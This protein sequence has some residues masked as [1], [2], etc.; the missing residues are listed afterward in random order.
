[1]AG[2]PLIERPGSQLSDASTPYGIAVASA[3]RPYI[4]YVITTLQLDNGLR[5]RAKQAPPP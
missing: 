5:W 3:L 2:T 1:M 4:N